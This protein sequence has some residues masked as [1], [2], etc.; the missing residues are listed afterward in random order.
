VV[1]VNLSQYA[2]GRHFAVW[3]R[4]YRAVLYFYRNLGERVLLPVRISVPC[5]HYSDR[6]LLPDFNCDDV[7]PAVRRGLRVV[8]EVFL[9]QWRQLALRVSLFRFLLCH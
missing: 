6:C 1:H 4:F 9:C 8:V 5:I 2:H 3:R 7:L